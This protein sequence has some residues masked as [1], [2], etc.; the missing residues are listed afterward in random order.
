MQNMI[1]NQYLFFVS[2]I[3]IIIV[4][5]VMATTYAYQS[6]RVDYISGSKS[7]LTVSSGVLDV[8]FEITNRIDIK[9]MVL[10]P[11]Y[12]TSDYIEF[13][14]DNTKSSSKVGYRISLVELEILYGLIQA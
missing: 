11:S 6:I 12:K 8:T 14:V 10:L 2:L 1:K 9:N 7:E 4:S 13:I 3:G 5:S